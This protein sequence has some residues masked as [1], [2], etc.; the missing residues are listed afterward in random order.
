VTGNTPGCDA[1]DVPDETGR[2][3]VAGESAYLPPTGLDL[4]DECPPR[5]GGES[6]D[7][8]V[9]VFAVADDHPVGERRYLD[10]LTLIG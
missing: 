2:A 3:G 4:A 8:A 7:R 5:V 10:A 1:R 9:R 6:Q